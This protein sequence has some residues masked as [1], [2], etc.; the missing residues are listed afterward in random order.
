MKSI[1]SLLRL[2][3]LS[4][5]SV[6]KISENMRRNHYISKSLVLLFA[7][8]A[9]CSCD[10][11]PDSRGGISFGVKSGDHST[12]ASYSGVKNSDNY[13]R[14][15]W[16]TGDVIRIYSDEASSP[17]AK[18]ADY[19]VSSVSA[20]D[21]RYS[22]AKVEKKS[23]D[24]CW[25][26]DKKHYFY[27]AYPAP[28]YSV[29]KSVGKN[30]IK[31]SIPAAQQ[32]YTIKDNTSTSGQY[33]LV[34]DLS[35]YLLMA[36]YAESKPIDKVD[37]DFYPITTCMDFT[38]TN[39]TG[40]SIEITELALI[41]GSGDEA[42][43][44]DFTCS[45][46]SGFTCTGGSSS[47]SSV[48]IPFTDDC[49]ITL[50]DDE[51]SLRFKFFVNPANDLTNPVFKVTTSDGQIR[52]V[53]LKKPGNVDFV[54]TASH[55]TDITGVVVKDGFVLLGFD[56]PILLNWETT[57]DL[58]VAFDS[59]YA[60]YQYGL[61][62]F[63]V[64]STRDISAEGGTVEIDGIVSYKVA[65][66]DPSTKIAVTPEVTDVPDW[67]EGSVSPT[68]FDTPTYKFTFTVSENPAVT[69][70]AKNVAY[71]KNVLKDTP[72]TYTDVSLYNPATGYVSPSSS[73]RNTAN[74]YVINA[75]GTYKI[76]MVYGNAIKDG[77]PNSGAYTYSGTSTSNIM[78]PN[79]LNHSGSNITSPYIKNVVGTS[80]TYTAE[81]VWT[82]VSGLISNVGVNDDEIDD[83]GARG[84]VTFTVDQD[85]IAQGNAIIAL[86][87]GGTTVWSWQIWVTDESLVPVNGFM[88]VNLGWC[89]T[90]TNPIVNKLAD[91]R[92]S[93]VTISFGDDQS[94]TVDVLQ[95]GKEEPSGNQ[96]PS[97][98][99]P[100]YQWGRKDPIVS[101]KSQNNSG[102]K[103]V[104]VAIQNPGTFYTASS[105][106]YT[107]VSD[108]YDN[109]WNANTN[110]SKVEKT[111]YDPCPAGFT[112]PLRSDVS[113]LVSPYTKVSYPSGTF[114]GYVMNGLYFPAMGYYHNDGNS[115]IS[116]SGTYG[117]YWTDQI[118]TGYNSRDNSYTLSFTNNS[119]PAVGSDNSRNNYGQ[120]NGMCVRPEIEK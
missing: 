71:H 40:D 48:Y 13:E 86:K 56:E 15:D 29:T 26:G 73:G 36:G 76:P 104:N 5:K 42:L 77:S 30:E 105:S 31:G 111:V 117:R 102:R 64:L 113:N 100:Y 79:F 21:T 82:E 62:N 23:D 95:S 1:L 109:L 106:Y 6:N 57:T 85:N 107:W 25:G 63:S 52:Q 28:G 16:S 74:C 84:F 101:G 12:K 112:V 47:D 78:R 19:V 27:C 10:I 87:Y 2:G 37:I 67:L 92:S 118:N 50:P 22:I 41:S 24:L 96:Y 58:P 65:Y 114:C 60:Y 89:A 3:L 53:T 90:D 39:G 33:E 18:Y 8:A 93:T 32:F 99:N 103:A 94:Y 59:E 17:A 43:S 83:S 38:I 88:P 51:T 54:V 44:G 9:V 55:K 14:I 120:A 66:T 81:V 35:R 46:D 69:S 119:N 80:S 75:P 11:E 108:Y 4:G 116:S 110:S 97:G 7:L 115:G 34:P 72:Q 98:T 68:S 49:Y 20:K 61:D 45:Y 91:P 70:V